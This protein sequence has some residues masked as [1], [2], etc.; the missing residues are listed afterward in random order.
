MFPL[1]QIIN[2]E[3]GPSQNL[4]LISREIMLLPLVNKDEYKLFSKYRIPTPVIG[5]PER[6]RQT[7]DDLA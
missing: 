5:V 2:V 6:R 7:D 3:V 4:K 1:V